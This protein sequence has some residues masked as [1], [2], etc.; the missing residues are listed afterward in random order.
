MNQ[1]MKLEFCDKIKIISF[2]DTLSSLREFVKVNL[3]I[4][5]TN[6]SFSYLLNSK[7]IQIENED[8]YIEAI[9]SFKMENRKLKIFIRVSPIKEEPLITQSQSTIIDTQ[10]LNTQII[11]S[12]PNMIIEPIVKSKGSKTAKSLIEPFQCKECKK[13][14]NLRRSYEMHH[15]NCKSV[16]L[17]KPKAF[18]IKKQRL[19]SI[20]KLNQMSFF[21]L[22]SLSGIELNERG[23]LDIAFKSQKSSCKDKSSKPKKG[24]D[25]SVNLIKKQE[26]KALNW[27]KASDK[28]RKLIKI[29]RMFRS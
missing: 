26:P 12:K 19:K 17:S 24:V 29:A 4:E 5:D 18:D 25:Q 23:E 6:I 9:N 28:M 10:T 15:P 1:I 20:A 13:K 7:E 27:K 21:H 22:I 16:F 2:Q 3:L 14:F 11:E 8:D